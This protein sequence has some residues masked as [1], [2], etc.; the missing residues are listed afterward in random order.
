MKRFLS[1]ALGL[2]LALSASGATYNSDG[3]EANINALITSATAGDT[4]TIPAGNFTIGTSKAAIAL[5]KAVILQGAGVGV[6]NITIATTAPS[7]SDG[8]G[9]FTVSA[10]ATIRDMTITQGG[11][12]LTNAIVTTTAAGGFRVTNCAYVSSTSAGY[13]IYS[14]CYGLVDSCSITGGAGNDEFIFTR[15]P[16]DS[17]QTAAGLGSQNA[18]VFED[19]TFNGTGYFDFNANSRAVV[20]N[21]TFTGPIKVDAHGAASNTPARSA[22]HVEIYNNTWTTN[23]TYWTVIEL[24]GGTFRCFNNSVPN[25]STLWPII[26]DYG[27]RGLWSAFSNVYQTPVNYPILD[28]IGVGMDPKVAGSEPAYMWGNTYG[29]NSPWVRTLKTPDAGAIS[30][31]QTQTSNPSATFTERDLIAPNRD[32]FA[33]AGFDNQTGVQVGTKAQMLAYT[34]TVTGYGWW[35]TDEGSW[36]TTKAANTSGQQYVWNGSAWV[37]NYVPLQY[38]HPLRGALASPTITVQPQ[39]VSITAGNGAAFAVSVV[40]NPAP[41]YQWRKGGVNIS[42]ATSS[43]YTISSTVSGD[44]GSYDCVITNSQGTATTSAA[45][46]T[47]NAGLVAPSITTQPQSVTATVGSPAYFS[48]T[49][50]GTAPLTYQWLK[51]GSTISGATSSSYTIAAT[52]SGDAGSYTVTV[53]NAQGSVTSSAA[54]LTVNA[55][56]VVIPAS[57][58]FIIGPYGKLQINQSTGN[59]VRKLQ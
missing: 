24:R 8:Y 32:Y 22:R 9:I 23:Y 36:D 4:I 37:L 47:V 6:T 39:S 21:C 30:L 41:T 50:T 53:T 20:R 51:N 45:T 31:Y 11:G 15:G 38:P 25:S 57:G 34:P 44:A 55:A 16:T 56:P 59:L 28:Q 58:G 12:S 40:A 27:Y 42:G 54:S 17:W 7:K 52:V 19:C 49:A 33:S 3:T 1:F 35:V 14:A 5:N 29:S 10:A 43:S 13:G 26:T 2:L 18:L 46:L 48:V